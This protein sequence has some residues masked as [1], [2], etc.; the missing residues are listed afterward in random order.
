MKGFA[1][2]T[3][4]EDLCLMELSRKA[5]DGRICKMKHKNM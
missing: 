5:I 4:E 1:E 2:A 3:Q